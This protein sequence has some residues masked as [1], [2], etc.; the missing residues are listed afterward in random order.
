M[1]EPRP[2]R[3]SREDFPRRGEIYL[4][5]LDRALGLEIKKTRPALVIQNDVT[6]RFG[7]LSQTYEVRSLTATELA[8]FRKWFADLHLEVRDR[9]LERAASCKIADLA[10]KSLIDH[11]RGKSTKL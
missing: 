9:Q 6:N 10:N 7:R 1:A 3:T 4:T 8:A 11:K 5:A 2:R